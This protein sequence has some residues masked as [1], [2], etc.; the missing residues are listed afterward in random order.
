MELNAVSCIIDKK[1]LNAAD[2]TQTVPLF[3]FVGTEYIIDIHVRVKTAFA[4]VT[5]PEVKV[6]YP[7]DLDRFFK[8]QPI[9]RTGDLISGPHYESDNICKKQS[10]DHTKT[11]TQ[12]QVIATFSSNSG[13][14]SSLTAGSI[15]FVVIYAK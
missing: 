15:E 10:P 8:L 14:F 1:I 13:N 9:N 7:D 6:G 5:R 3:D 11:E 12:K 4:G 2:T